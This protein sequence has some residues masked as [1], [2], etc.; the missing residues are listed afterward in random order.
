MSREQ[1][2]CS[3]EKSEAGAVDGETRRGDS[4]VDGSVRTAFAQSA[5]SEAGRGAANPDEP[6]ILLN[7]FEKVATSHTLTVQYDPG[8]IPVYVGFVLLTLSLS[9]VFFFSHQRLWAVVE[10][11]GKQSRVHFGGHTNRNKPAF[12]VRFDT[13][14]RAS[15][16]GKAKI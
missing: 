15:I 9:G 8:R 12:E 10:P 1:T 3:S 4:L 2:E 13:V 5:R 16:G 6:G 11:H 14:V 7:S